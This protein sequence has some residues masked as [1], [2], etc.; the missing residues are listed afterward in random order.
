[1]LRAWRTGKFSGISHKRVW[2]CPRAQNNAYSFDQIENRKGAFKNFPRAPGSARTTPLNRRAFST[3]LNAEPQD[4]EDSIDEAL[5]NGGSAWMCDMLGLSLRGLQWGDPTAPHKMLCVHGY[6]DN[7]MSFATLAPLLLQDGRRL[8]I[9]AVDLP[10]HGQSDHF[11]ACVG[12]YRPEVIVLS[13][14]HSPCTVPG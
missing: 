13:C 5:A 1:M 10:G 14:I 12:T 9:V 2:I 8:H 11:P 7:A 4:S 3:S 6:M